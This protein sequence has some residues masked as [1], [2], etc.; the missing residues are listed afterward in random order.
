MEKKFITITETKFIKKE[1]TSLI[2]INGQEI[3]R[4]K[5]YFE[6]TGIDNEGKENCRVEF[7]I[8]NIPLTNNF[9]ENQEIRRKIY[10]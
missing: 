9:N 7:E 2:N 1:K 6:V 3:F 5:L 8:V 10:V 4:E